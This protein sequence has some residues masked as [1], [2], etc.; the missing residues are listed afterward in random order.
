MLRNP[1]YINDIGQ[2]NQKANTGQNDDN[3]VALININCT[4]GHN[5]NLQQ[6]N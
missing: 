3:S 6:L 1:K 5:Y 4:R 2:T